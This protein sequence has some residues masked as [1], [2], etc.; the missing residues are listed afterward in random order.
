MNITILIAG[1]LALL[2]FFIHSFIGDKEYRALIPDKETVAKNKDTWVQ[3]RCGWHWVSVD[4]LIT[5]I[6]LLLMATTEIIQ[7][8]AEISL[9]LSI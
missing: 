5:G 1:V 3:V 8:K 7:A 9:L 4:L 6:I 2:A